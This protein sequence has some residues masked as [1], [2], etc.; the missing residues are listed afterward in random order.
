L[1]ADKNSISAA[2]GLNLPGSLRYTAGGNSRGVYDPQYTNVAPRIG[3]T[4]APTQRLVVRAAFGVFY[5]PVMEFGLGPL[6]GSQGLSLNGFSQTTPYV[7]TVDGITP[8]DVLSNPFP[9]GLLLPP[10]KTLGDRTDLGL[11]INA[12]ERDRPTPYVEQWT[13][14][15]Q[16]QVESNTVL[17]AAYVGNHGVKLP[18]GANF[19]R[20]QLRPEL[21]AMGNALL[22]PVS[23]PFFGLITSGPLSG[24]TVPQGR[25]LR[26]YPQ[27]DSIIAVQP[28]A[29]MSNYNAFT[30]SANRRFS[31]GLHFQVSFTASKYLTNTEG[32]EGRRPEPKPGAG[33]PQLLRHFA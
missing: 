16:Y 24:R 5:S 11:S 1:D 30:L 26:P 33:N 28:P 3:L 29:G 2:A 21:L 18:F 22:Q 15:L 27:F 32:P 13:F 10:G 7:G 4:Y 20:N 31:H 23:N 8:R 6:G 19:Q 17:E 12:V 25:L 14:G 9:A